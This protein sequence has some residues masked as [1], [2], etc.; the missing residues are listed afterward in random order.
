ML[1]SPG[2]SENCIYMFSSGKSLTVEMLSFGN[3][4]WSS[5]TELI[6][7]KIDNIF[8]SNNFIISVRITISN[9]EPNF[10]AYPNWNEGL[11]KVSILLD[12]KSLRHRLGKGIDPQACRLGVSWCG[13]VVYNIIYPLRYLLG[14]LCHYFSQHY[15]IIRLLKTTHPI[16]FLD[17]SNWAEQLREKL[18]KKWSESDHFFQLFN[19]NW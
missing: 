2:K 4:W 9:F 17:S 16:A 5:R 3:F 15:Y 8:S 10:R 7:S 14:L 11:L 19:R 18:I 12:C 6:D 13:S 1:L